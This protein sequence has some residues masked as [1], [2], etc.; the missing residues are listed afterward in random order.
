MMMI[1]FDK[2]QSKCGAHPNFRSL[3][4]ILI[5]K[6]V[7]LMGVTSYSVPVV[8]FES[9]QVNEVLKLVRIVMTMVVIFLKNISPMS[10][11]RAEKLSRRLEQHSRYCIQEKT[12]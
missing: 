8:L 1:T 4:K 9:V 2:K 11:R 6:G 10:E 7:S 5:A 12:T 3:Q